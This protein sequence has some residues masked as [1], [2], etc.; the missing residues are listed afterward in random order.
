MTLEFKVPNE[1]VHVFVQAVIETLEQLRYGYEYDEVSPPDSDGNCRV[2]VMGIVPDT[3]SYSPKGS[4]EP[5]NR[6]D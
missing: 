6:D 2:R 3:L 5:E 1:T 4:Y